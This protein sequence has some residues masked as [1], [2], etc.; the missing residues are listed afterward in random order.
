MKQDA[1]ANDLSRIWSHFTN[2]INYHHKIFL[3]QLVVMETPVSIIGH[4]ITLRTLAKFPSW[5]YFNTI[6]ISWMKCY[7]I[8]LDFFPQSNG[9]LGQM[10]SLFY[11]RNEISFDEV[12]FAPNFYTT[13]KKMRTSYIGMALSSSSL[14]KIFS[15]YNLSICWYLLIFII[16]FQT[17]KKRLVLIVGVMA[18]IVLELGNQ[19]GP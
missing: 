2:E 15:C 14:D 18:Q 19:K 6:L 17:T 7:I 3:D 9:V 10:E 5:K 1:L 8:A 13:A 12:I 16:R 4:T 11:T